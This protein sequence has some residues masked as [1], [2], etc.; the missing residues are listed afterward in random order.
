MATLIFQSYKGVSRDED[1]CSV[2]KLDDMLLEHLRKLTTSSR[3]WT[4]FRVGKQA[5]RQGF[6][7]LAAKIF[8]NLSSKVASEHFYFWLIALKFFCEAESLLS[9]SCDSQL[10]LAKQISDAC[11]KYHKGITTLKVRSTS[12]FS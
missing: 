11:A 7:S 8:G 12:H 4:M 10:A 9:V 3:Y 5:T 6:H 1:Q 2:T